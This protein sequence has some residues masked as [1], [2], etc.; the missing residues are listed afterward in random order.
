[1][2]LTS[3]EII[4]LDCIM[5]AVISVC[6]KEILKVGESLCGHFNI[7]DGREEATFWHIMLYYF[8]KGWNATE[9]QNHICSVYGEG[10]MTD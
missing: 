7:E 2:P 10:A 4:L 6:I 8:K 1:L 9:M 5:T 3:F